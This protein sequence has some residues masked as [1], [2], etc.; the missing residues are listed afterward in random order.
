MYDWLYKIRPYCLSCANLL[1][2][3][4]LLFCF[5][6]PHLRLLKVPWLGV[7]TELQLLA[8]TTATVMRDPQP[9]E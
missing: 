2:L 4:L 7:E 1:L 8:Y 9:I 6:R 5:L 3:L